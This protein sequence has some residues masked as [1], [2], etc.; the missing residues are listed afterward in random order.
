[1]SAGKER[2]EN[3]TPAQNGKREGVGWLAPAPS[4]PPPC[5]A[6]TLAS[7][8][9][10]IDFFVLKKQGG[11]GQSSMT[12]NYCACVKICFYVLLLTGKILLL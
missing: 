8:A 6:L 11:C 10:S 2:R 3:L 12:I 9:D 1:M 5:F 4:P 7:F